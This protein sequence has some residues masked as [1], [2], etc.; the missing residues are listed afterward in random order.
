MIVR[1]FSYLHPKQ[2]SQA[3]ISISNCIYKDIYTINKNA[4]K[5]NFQTKHKNE[6]KSNFQQKHAPTAYTIFTNNR[7]Y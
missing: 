1:G 5:R 2:L 7:N 6:D 4:N 3:I